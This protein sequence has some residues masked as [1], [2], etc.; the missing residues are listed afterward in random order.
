MAMSC[1][2]SHELACRR[3]R[4]A[5]YT[6]PIALF[7]ALLIRLA[8]RYPQWSGYGTWHLG[9][10]LAIMFVFTLLPLLC[11]V[12]DLALSYGRERTASTSSRI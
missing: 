4:Y 9:G 2:G 6:V 7:E 3:F 11:A 5:W 8:Y 1:F 10:V 12:I